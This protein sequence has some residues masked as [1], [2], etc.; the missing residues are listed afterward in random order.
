M[1][2][3]ID[4]YI[5]FCNEVIT[6]EQIVNE[7]S[8]PS[9][10]KSNNTMSALQQRVSQVINDHSSIIDQNILADKKIKVDCGN[11]KLS[12]F[13]LQPRKKEYTWWGSE[14]EGSGC[15]SYGCCYDV[16]QNSQ[17]TLSAVN[18][19]VIN[20]TQKIFNEVKQELENQVDLTVGGGTGNTS[21]TGAINK[22]ENTSIEGI[23]RVLENLAKTDVETSQNIKIVSVSPLA[24]VNNCD[25]SPSA[26]RI[27]QSLNIDIASKNIVSIITETVI[28][29]YVEMESK[30]STKVTDVD[31]KKIYTFI[32]SF[33]V[34]V[35]LTYI[36]C[37]FLAYGL[38]KVLKA[39][40]ITKPAGM[41]LEKFHGRCGCIYPIIAILFM[42]FIYK[43]WIMIM[44]MVSDPHREKCGFWCDMAGGFGCWLEYF[45]LSPTSLIR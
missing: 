6:G 25:E 2:S 23:T 43:C 32:V 12:K 13:H 19:T 33:V 10:I 15:P 1:S 9:V 45:P 30:T 38:V 44:C 4:E 41:T 34:S 7:D 17:I 21:I 40:A 26:G 35:V 16:S 29:N 24:C 18:S 28:E 3:V 5:V 39:I 36:I 27:N 31:I 42:Y 20:D 8:I 22:S 37:W 11:Q 14:V